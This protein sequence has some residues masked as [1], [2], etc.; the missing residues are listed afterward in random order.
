MMSAVSIR[1]VLPADLDRCAAIEAACYGPEGATRERI[2]HR[3]VTYPEGFLVADLDRR[4]VGFVNSGATDKQDISDEA[5]KGLI[6]HTPEGMH[7]VIFSLA[8]EPDFQGQ[9]IGRALMQVLIETAKQLR[10]E[11]ILLL[12]QPALLQYYQRFGFRDRG[13]SASTHG[14]LQ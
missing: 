3:I 9:N 12:C 8:V 7:L 5:L 13:V 1:H 11:S 14:G 4:V 10:K 6:G 2:E